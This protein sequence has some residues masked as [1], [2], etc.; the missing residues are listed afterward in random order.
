MTNQTDQTIKNDKIAVASFVLGIISIFLWELSIFPLLAL[1]L[2]I[3]GI[4]RTN[5]SGAGMWMAITG[6][7]LGILFLIVRLNH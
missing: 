3:V 5:K 7:V 1:I 4:V 6:T 2:G